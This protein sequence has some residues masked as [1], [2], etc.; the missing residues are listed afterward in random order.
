M[1]NLQTY[2]PQFPENNQQVTFLETVFTYNKE[3][4]CWSHMPIDFSDN[5]YHMDNYFKV[6]YSTT[7][8]YFNKNLFNWNTFNNLTFSYNK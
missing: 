1:E 2:F 8:I 6:I 3:L 7:T 4:D 5:R